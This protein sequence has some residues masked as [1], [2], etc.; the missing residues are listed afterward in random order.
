MWVVA[1]GTQATAL[2]VGG[3]RTLDTFNRPNGP[4]GGSWSK[5]CGS[6]AGFL[7]WSQALTTGGR[8]VGAYWNAQSFGRG[9]VAG[10]TVSALP[11][12]GGST[13]SLLLRGV[14]VGGPSFGGY[15]CRWT[16]RAAAPDVYEI[17]RVKNG[18]AKRLTATGA[19]EMAPGEHLGC[20]AIGNT[21]IAAYSNSSGR[22]W[23]V[24][25]RATDKTYRAGGRIGVRM[26]GPSFHAR[27][28]DFSGGTVG[29]ARPACGFGSLAAPTSGRGRGRGRSPAPS[30][31]H[32]LPLTQSGTGVYATIAASGDTL[33]FAYLDQRSHTVYYRRSSDQGAS[34]S[35]PVAV[36][37]ADILILT[38]PLAANGKTLH[39]VYQRGDNLYYKHSTDNGATWGGESSLDGEPPGRYYRA[40][41]D[42]SGSSVYVAWASHSDAD[43]TSNGL[44]FR[45]SVDGGATWSARQE[46]APA[47]D[48]PGRPALS[49]RDGVVH[50]VWTD[51]RD[52]NPPCYTFPACPEIY[53]RRS[54]NGGAS[55]GEARRM[56][57]GRGS[58]EGRPDIAALADGS[59]SLVWQ[60]DMHVRGEEELFSMQSR[61]KG[62]TWRNNRRLTFARKESS[63]CSPPR[64]ARPSSSP[65][66][67][68]AT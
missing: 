13:V 20:E 27:L 68:G 28:D 24:A 30:W 15:E 42:T 47:A 25:V 50:L 33:H 51:A 17:V 14:R 41:V 29:C 10:L 58:T 1:T 55:W 16:Y 2:T 39:I 23:K 52:R 45:R 37:T 36:G 32:E 44:F 64:T 57:F 35:A 3:V 7:I 61:D 53:Y 59:V 63:H 62:A 12:F 34:W 9:E 46:L 40:S 43:F 65:G 54:V 48:D 31:S 5:C 49:A 8:P 11:A 18:V 56:T 22:G 60:N 38:E 21:V 19:H 6:P 26:T 4:I 66:S 67:T